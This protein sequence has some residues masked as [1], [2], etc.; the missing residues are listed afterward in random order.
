MV[1]YYYGDAG[2]WLSD[3]GLV[4]FFGFGTIV[5]VMTIGAL[6][7]TVIVTYHPSI[8]NEW[9]ISSSTL[10]ILWSMFVITPITLVRNFGNLSII[11]YYIFLVLIISFCMICIVAPIEYYH[12]NKNLSLRWGSW[13][14]GLLSVGTIL[15]FNGLPPAII[16]SYISTSSTA[17][18][19][20]LNYIFITIILSVMLEY[21]VGLIGYLTFRSNT[22]SDLL[23]NFTSINTFYLLVQI[24]YMFLIATSTPLYLIISRDAILKMYRMIR[25]QE[26]KSSLSARVNY[27]NSNH[28]NNSNNK[29][30][31]SIKLLQL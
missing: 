2:E 15:Y 26:T 17:K 12:E 21:I 25:K 27:Y 29:H 20:F 11:S 22:S 30:Q 28:S 1:R 23:D 7:R 10:I 13:K 6:T 9:Y 31:P 3:I 5:P 16:D 24:A 4:I 14:G 8:S 19:H 18:P